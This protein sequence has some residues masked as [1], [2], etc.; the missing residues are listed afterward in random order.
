[1]SRYQHKEAKTIRDFILA[2]RSPEHRRRL[3]CV[4]CY[5]GAFARLIDQTNIDLVLVGDSVGNVLLGFDGTIPVTV[6]HMVHHTAAVSRCLN[7]PLLC[8]DM[9]FLSYHLSESQALANA[10]RLV[11]EGG[12]QCVKMEGGASI[13]PQVKKI[14]SAGIPVMGHLG[15]TPQSVHQMGGYR[16]QGRDSDSRDLL[17]REARELEDAGVFAL[18]LEVIPHDLAAQV[19]EA[20]KIPTI[21]IGAGP[22]CDGQILV[23]H[24][25]LGFDSGFKPKFLKKYGDLG[26]Q[27]VK[28]LESYDKEVKSGEF[29]TMEHSF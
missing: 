4:T 10:A 18:V 7:K 11:Q 6:D 27:I 25:L 15:L 17:I 24:D 3:T 28:A 16:V 26:S 21:G 12:A 1:M 19:T 8:A 23:L 13:V 20:L 5:D 14:V 9:P 29:P 22:S 2:K